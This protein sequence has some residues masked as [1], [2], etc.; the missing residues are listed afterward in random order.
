MNK[1]NAHLFYI[2]LFLTI[3][4]CKKPYYP[5]IA[6]S[7]KSYL[8]VEGIINRGND[9]TFIRLS[10]TIKLAD[11][12]GTNAEKGAVVTVDA[13]GGI[14]Y[15]LTEIAPGTYA[16][17]PLSLDNTKKYRLAIETSNGQNY[18]SEEMGVKEAPPIDSIGYKITQNGILVYVNAHDATNNTRY[19]RWDYEETWRFHPKYKSDYVSDGTKIVRRTADNDVYTCYDH[20]A[21]NNVII[22]STTKLSQDIVTNVPLVNVDGTSLKLNDRYTILVKQYALSKQA[23][24]FWENLRK[25]TEQLGS[26][27]DA[28]P[29][30]I[31]G[32]IHNINNPNEIVIGFIEVGTI[33][34]KRIYID[35]TELP[36]W[37]TEYLAECYIDTVY[38]NRNGVNE[39]ENLL[40]PKLALPLG[41]IGTEDYTRTM[42]ECGD[43]TLHG[44]TQKPVFW[45]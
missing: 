24:D 29:S 5:S 21:S 36:R 23:Y 44:T 22:T 6:S 33:Q 26:I 20:H 42:F 3:M 13:D 35:R 28:Q 40:V 32:N 37:N 41:I 11:G 25:N 18:Q 43:C 16:A 34:S 17:G 31:S 14:S 9:S 12:I 10:R 4:S 38:A 15:S 30:E 19:Y 45:K 39:V 1:I 2:A 27:F 8:V 7:A